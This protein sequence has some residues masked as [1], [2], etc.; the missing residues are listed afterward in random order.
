[1]E[2][3]RPN[4]L[5]LKQFAQIGIGP[6]LDVDVLDEATKRGL[7][8]AANDG[9]NLL[10]AALRQGQGRFHPPIGAPKPV[11]YRRQRSG[12]GD[13]PEHFDRSRRATAHRRAELL[14]DTWK[15]PEAQPVN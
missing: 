9:R 4:G 6:G 10:E 12:G 8:R 2:F 1:M 11:G 14:N 13:L 3:H 15:F 5:L 7:A